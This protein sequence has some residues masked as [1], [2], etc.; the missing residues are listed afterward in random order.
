MEKLLPS[1][2]I[3]LSIGAA[4]VYFAQHDYRKGLYWVFAAGLTTTV[5]F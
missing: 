2:M 5:T 3:L 1:A 4:I